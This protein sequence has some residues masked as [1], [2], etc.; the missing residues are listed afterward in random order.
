L[1]IHVTCWQ[2][3][4]INLLLYIFSV[5]LYAFIDSHAVAHKSVIEQQKSETTTPLVSRHGLEA[6]Y[7]TYIDRD[8]I[9]IIALANTTTE[10]AR[11]RSHNEAGQ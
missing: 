7:L 8:I 2:Y 10:Q 3:L 4:I 5:S 9:I 11:E 6:S 1:Y